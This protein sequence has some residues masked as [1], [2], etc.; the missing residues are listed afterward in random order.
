VMEQWFLY[1]RRH[2]ACTS[3]S[4]NM[5][6]LAGMVGATDQVSQGLYVGGDS[7]YSHLIGSSTL[8]RSKSGK[9]LFRVAVLD[10]SALKV[11]SIY[12]GES[13]S[14]PLAWYTTGC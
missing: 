9:K 6:I 2:A 10:N 5:D 13:Q 11:C 14:S 4:T 1:G 3:S 12:N 8:G 7:R